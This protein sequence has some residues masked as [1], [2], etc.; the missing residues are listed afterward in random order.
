MIKLISILFLLPFSVMGILKTRMN[1][2]GSRLTSRFLR[3]PS[4]PG[5]AFCRD[6]WAAAGVGRQETSVLSLRSV[7][8][9]QPSL[10]AGI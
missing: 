6:L 5:V 9:T 7:V 10:G 2:V 1:W 8:W 3:D 4:P